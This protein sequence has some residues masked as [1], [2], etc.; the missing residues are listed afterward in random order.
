NQQKDTRY[1]KDEL[2]VLFVHGVLHLLG[3]D[4]LRTNDKKNMQDLENQILN[5]L[6]NEGVYC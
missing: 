3:F 2:I 4:H 5:T 1:L 6:K